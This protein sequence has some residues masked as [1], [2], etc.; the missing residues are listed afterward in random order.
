[1]VCLDCPLAK[2]GLKW[3]RK[4]SIDLSTMSNGCTGRCFL[5]PSRSLFHRSAQGRGHSLLWNH[6]NANPAVMW[7]ARQDPQGKQETQ[8]P[9]NAAS[10][11]GIALI[12]RGSRSRMLLRGKLFPYSIWLPQ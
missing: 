2:K 10:D 9:D 3:V 4:G 11:S 6:W 5:I 8:Y 1:M 12:C 7:Q